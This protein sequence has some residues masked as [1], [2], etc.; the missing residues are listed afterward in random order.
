MPIQPA[1]QLTQIPPFPALSDRAAGLYN[2][3]AYA[4]GVH[5]GGTDAA[6]PGLFVAEINAL[7]DN[8]AHNAQEAEHAATTSRDAANTATTQSDAAMGYRNAA[9][10]AAATATTKAGEASASA[11]S[12]SK[13]NLGDKATPPMTD[14]QGAPLRAGATYYDTTINKWRVW[15]GTAWGDGISAVAGVSSLNGLTGALNLTTLAAYGITDAVAQTGNQSIS[16]VKRFESAAMARQDTST[17]G[18]ELIFERASDGFGHYAIEVVGTGATPRMRFVNLQ[19]GAETL[20]IY[21]DGSTSFE[22]NAT[23][24]AGVQEAVITANTGAAYTINL[25]SGTIFNL[26]LTANCTYTFP[27]PDAGKQFT[28]LQKQD[29]TGS[30]TV[31]WPSTVRWDGGGAPILTATAGRTDVF[32]FISDGTYWLGFKGPKNYNRA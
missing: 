9:Q 22:G 27:A 12:A 13:L 14:N 23:F 24:K 3:K 5:M 8:V 30:R 25:G 18:G 7:A 19:R 17:E 32:T 21:H 16:G 11:I 28:I 15:T 2:T 26:T 10:A 6:T 1:A 4:F 29:A 31:T 20:G